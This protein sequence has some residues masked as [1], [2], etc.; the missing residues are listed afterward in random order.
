M[1]TIFCSICCSSYFCNLIFIYL[2]HILNYE[3]AVYNC[4]MISNKVFQ[5]D[6]TNIFIVLKDKIHSRTNIFIY[7]NKDI[8]EKKISSSKTYFCVKSL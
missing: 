6:K 7:M 1:Y 5:L 8:F 3:Y 2:L 4:Y